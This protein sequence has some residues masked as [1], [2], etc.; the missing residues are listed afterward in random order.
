MLHWMV[1]ERCE[2][3]EKSARESKSKK[4]SKSCSI[5]KNLKFWKFSRMPHVH[6]FNMTCEGRKSVENWRSSN[7]F[8]D[9]SSPCQNFPPKSANSFLKIA[10]IKKPKFAKNSH[11]R[12]TL[13]KLWMAKIGW[14]LPPW[15]Q[16]QNVFKKLFNQF[17]DCLKSPGLLWNVRHDFSGPKF[18]G[19]LKNRVGMSGKTSREAPEP[20]LCQK[21]EFMAP[22][23]K[24]VQNLE[25]PIVFQLVWS[26]SEKNEPSTR[27]LAL[28]LSELD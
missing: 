6:T 7:H 10:K 15:E 21:T 11:C 22:G 2:S 16:I 13:N 23:S 14:K 9:S 27:F 12:P 25:I 19:T 24:M 4:C 18:I 8:F 20:V 5:A 28:V 17:L 26:H 1:C 3:D